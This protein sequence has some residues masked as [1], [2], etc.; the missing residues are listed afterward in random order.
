MDASVKIR[1]E[2]LKQFMHDFDI[3]QAKLGRHLGFKQSHI[4]RILNGAAAPN[5]KFIAKMMTTY[6]ASFDVFFFVDAE[7]AA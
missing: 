7:I 6:D 5:A 1:S 3:S 4:S 2:F